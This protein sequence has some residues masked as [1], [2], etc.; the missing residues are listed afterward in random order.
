MKNF[1]MK[2]AVCGLGAYV[3]YGTDEIYL[4]EPHY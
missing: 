1:G 3:V 4:Q 2:L